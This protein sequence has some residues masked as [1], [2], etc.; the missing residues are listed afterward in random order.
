MMTEEEAEEATCCQF[1]TRCIAS[2]CMAWRWERVVEPVDPA[3]KFPRVGVVKRG[4]RG[5]CGLV[6]KPEVA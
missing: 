1:E 2:R 6:G 3:T 5:Y 4:E